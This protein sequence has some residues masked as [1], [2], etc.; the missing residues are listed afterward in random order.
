MLRQVKRFLFSQ[1]NSLFPIIHL[2]EGET[3]EQL[4]SLL[5]VV[6]YG[7]QISVEPQY[8]NSGFTNDTI[9]MF[10]KCPPSIQ[11]HHTFVIKQLDSKLILY[12]LFVHILSSCPVTILDNGHR[13]SLSEIQMCNCY[14]KPLQTLPPEDV[15]QG[16][17]SGVHCFKCRGRFFTSLF[18]GPGD[19]PP[20][21]FSLSK[22]W[23]S[24]PSGA[25]LIHCS[26]KT[27]FWAAVSFF[28]FSS[29]SFYFFFS[30]PRESDQGAVLP[31]TRLSVVP[32]SLVLLQTCTHSSL[33]SDLT[34]QT[35]G[36]SCFCYHWVNTKGKLSLESLLKDKRH[37]FIIE[38]PQYVVDC[39]M[40]MIITKSDGLKITIN[41]IN[42]FHRYF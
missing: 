20:S 37:S 41:F 19:S 40:M 15:L 26:I 34:P 42:L 31:W 27:P 22:W 28:A 7:P 5:N 24:S 29:C 38:D 12:S 14:I 8:L 4:D 25:S 33:C 1:A 16:E 23:L 13:C 36:T 9:E 32:W 11:T 3:L 17:G 10:S 30:L 6:H 2:L 18:W 35:P 21:T 39:F